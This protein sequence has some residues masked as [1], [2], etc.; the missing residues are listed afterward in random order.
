[1]QSQRTLIFDNKAHPI[2]VCQFW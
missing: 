1:M 2:K